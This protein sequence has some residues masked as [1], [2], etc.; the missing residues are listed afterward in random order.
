MTKKSEYLIKEPLIMFVFLYRKLVPSSNWKMVRWC[1]RLKREMSFQLMQWK[2]PSFYFSK[3]RILFLENLNMVSKI[4]RN[5]ISILLLIEQLY[6]VIF[7]FLNEEF[8]SKNSVHICSAKKQLV[9][10]KTLDRERQP[11]FIMLPPQESLGFFIWF[12]FHLFL[13]FVLESIFEFLWWV[14]A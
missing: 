10:I 7:V 9:C 4:K 8:I 1:S 14:L 2:M 13:I 3:N 6:S 5:F 12:G 11:I